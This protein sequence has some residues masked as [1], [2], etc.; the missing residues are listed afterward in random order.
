MGLR[1]VGSIAG[2]AHCHARTMVG[3]FRLMTANLLNGM[4]DAGHLTEVLDRVRPDVI[5]T[6]EMGPDL[7]E[8]IARL[9]LSRFRWPLPLV[10]DGRSL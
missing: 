7:A 4:A 9:L 5:V 10:F 8:V 6:Q 1:K 3:R 2:P